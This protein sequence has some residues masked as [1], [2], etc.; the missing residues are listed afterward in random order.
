V[1]GWADTTMLHAQAKHPVCA[2]KWMNWSLT[3]KVQGDLAAWFG[4]LP[5]VLKGVKP[6]RCWVIKAAKPTAITSSTKSCSGKRRLPKAANCPL[7]P[8]DAGL[9][10]DYGRPLIAREQ[11]MTY[12]VEFHNVSRLYGDVRA[13]DGVTIASVT[14][15]FLHAGAFRL[16][17]N[18]LPA[19]DCRF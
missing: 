13:V 2:Y 14:A 11:N 4:S 7:Q 16:R 8:L 10:R 5:V 3:P 18:H 17:Q 12:A 1:T 6:A 19:A 15:I 9:H